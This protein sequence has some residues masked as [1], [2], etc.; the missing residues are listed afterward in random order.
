MSFVIIMCI[1]QRYLE[2]TAWFEMSVMEGAEQALLGYMQIELRSE[3]AAKA[4]REM[5]DEVKGRLGVTE[6]SFGDAHCTTQAAPTPAMPRPST[7]PRPRSPAPVK[8][9]SCAHAQCER[10]K[11]TMCLQEVCLCTSCHLQ[12]VVPLIIV[13]P[14]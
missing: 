4:F 1:S 6:V 5:S 13:S 7:P 14:S 3:K 10:L 9:R 12:S 2:C 11:S 8:H